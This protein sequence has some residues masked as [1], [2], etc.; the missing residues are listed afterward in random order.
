[1]DHRVRAEQA[2]EETV[3]VSIAIAIAVGRAGFAARI[4]F[5]Y[6]AAAL[7][8]AGEANVD[9]LAAEAG[10]FDLLHFADYMAGFLTMS[11]AAAMR[12][13]AVAGIIVG[14]NQP[15]RKKQ[16]SE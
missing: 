12:T 14:Q 4:G 9:V 15:G 6:V 3:M 5:A 13:T 16:R 11:L 2:I 7:A 10:R 8:V 1:M